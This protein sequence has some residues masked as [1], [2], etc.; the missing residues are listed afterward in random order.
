MRNRNILVILITSTFVMWTIASCNMGGVTIDQRI[1]D[2]QS[3]LNTPDR[4]SAYQD[5]DPNMTDYSEL[6]SGSF[7]LTDFPV[8]PSNYTLSVISESNTSAVIV[9]V[10]TGPSTVCGF[11]IAAGCYLNLNMTEAS[12][13]NW[14]IHAL[15]AASSSS[16]GSWTPEL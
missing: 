2:F 9:Q 7:F 13:N 10:T 5:F 12:G 8:P 14:L 4:S 16:P 3:D 6:K 11:T 1:A 15:S